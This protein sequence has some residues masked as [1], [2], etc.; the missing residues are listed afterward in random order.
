MLF[1]SNIVKDLFEV[2]NTDTG[3]IQ[4]LPKS[5]VLE[6]ASSQH[7]VGVSSNKIRAV[8]NAEVL[9]QLKAKY[10]LAGTLTKLEI[11]VDDD[12]DVVDDAD[13]RCRFLYCSCN[14]EKNVTN[15]LY[16]QEEI[17]GVIGP[18]VSTDTLYIPRSITNVGENAF[19]NL[20][21]YSNVKLV[22]EDIG[23]VTNW[24]MNA[25]P[26][27]TDIR[28]DAVDKYHFDGS[29]LIIS[30]DAYIPLQENGSIDITCDKL[31]ICDNAFQGGIV[32]SLR[33]NC[34]D[35]V[36]SHTRLEYTDVNYFLKPE[37]DYLLEEVNFW[38]D[39]FWD[40]MGSTRGVRKLVANK[41]VLDNFY[42][43][44]YISD[45]PSICDV[46]F[47]PDA[48]EEDALIAFKDKY[49]C[50]QCGNAI[51][52]S[53]LYFEI[54][55]AL[56][57]NARLRRI[58]ADGLISGITAQQLEWQDSIWKNQKIT[59]EDIAKSTTVRSVTTCALEKVILI[60]DDGTERE[61]SLDEYFDML[62]VL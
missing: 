26:S 16:G 45:T 11:F 21:K 55:K 43:G 51:N 7:I 60:E 2:T 57:P 32:S 3:E 22:F 6:K 15:I 8:S 53:K 42:F 47:S 30:A 10:N 41:V 4:F 34:R 37:D 13:T 23:A 28:E 18:E 1:I 54:Y 44:C 35:I 46:F 56:H 27:T 39:D 61:L 33:L 25:F 49:Y 17:G 19:Y 9:E 12:D 5:E 38:S 50:A 59:A 31:M 40:I 48:F 58:P 52:P 20:L 29:I 14:K 62:G 36:V 24:G